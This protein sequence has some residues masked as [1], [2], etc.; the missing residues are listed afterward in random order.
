MPQ[1]MLPAPGAP[2]TLAPNDLSSLLGDT[3]GPPATADYR[4][5]Y[6][7]NDQTKRPVPPPPPDRGRGGGAPRQVLPTVPSVGVDPMSLLT[8]FNA[9]A[10]LYGAA[11]AVLDQQQKVAQARSDLATLEKSGTA[12]QS[13][14]VA[15]RNELQRAEREQH[16][17]ELR[18]MEAKQSATNKQLKSLATTHDAMS[19]LGAGLDK[20]L[21]ISKGL[22]GLAD[23]LVRFLG[24]LA[25]APLMAQL[26]AIS[27]ANPSQGGYGVSGIL[28]AQG[29]FG[30]DHTG[31][32]PTTGPSTVAGYPGMAPGYGGQPYG[33]PAGTN[34][35]GYGSS[36]AV[37]PQWVHALEQIFGVKASTYA[38]HQESD[39]NEPGYAPNPMHQNRGI[40]WTGSPDAMQRFAN[41]MASQP[42]AEQVIYQNPLTGQVTESIA[43]QAR[44][45]YFAGDL[46]AHQNHVHTRQA[47]S[48]MPPMMDPYG[49]MTGPATV[50]AAGGA[51]M[52]PG[53]GMSQALPGVAPLGG[54]GPGSV[55][56]GAQNPTQIGATVGPPNGTGQGGINIDGSGLISNAGDRQRRGR[57]GCR[58]RG[59]TRILLRL[60]GSP[61]RAARGDE[62]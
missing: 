23:N 25:A 14:I 21:G 35:G 36:G 10:S 3:A 48:I 51:P 50:P 38:G 5:W 8:G 44:P 30:P 41:Y 45:G 57:R 58:D 2:G 6:G 52:Y 4:S 37:F 9:D 11:G 18:L 55:F 46:G 29:V 60:H 56:A 1:M 16:E 53:T 17:A 33:L 32:A 12:T 49:L 19:S 31:I 13:E 61:V 34:T 7:N 27:K 26:D 39:R 47:Q 24:S 42:N 15:K 43:G 20:D 59:R 28:A 22:P 54:V 40:D 62:H